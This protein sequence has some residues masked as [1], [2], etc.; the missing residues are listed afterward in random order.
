M[1]LDSIAYFQALATSYNVTKATLDKMSVRGWNTL[2]AFAFSCSAPQGVGSEDK[3]AIEVFRSLDV[4]ETA[5]APGLRRLYFDAW[6]A[7]S[8]VTKQKFERREDDPPRKLPRIELQDRRAALQKILGKG[9]KLEH[10]N[11]PSDALV[12]LANAMLENDVVRHIHVSKCTSRAQELREI[13]VEPSLALDRNGFLKLGEQDTEVHADCSS[14]L[15]VQNAL[16]RRG[17]AL[18]LANVLDFE[19]HSLLVADFMTAAQRPIPGHGVI[20]LDRLLLW[21]QEIWYRLSQVAT[22]GVKTSIDGKRPLDALLL[23]VLVEP[24]LAILLLPV[25]SQNA[26]Q[27]KHRDKER[28]NSGSGWRDNKISRLEQ[29]IANLKRGRQTRG[30]GHGKGAG[31][32]KDKG[33][34]GPCIRKGELAGCPYTW[35]GETPLLHGA[36]EGVQE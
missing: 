12:D 5:E 19:V 23:Q 29:E 13:K 11:D 34:A 3:F 26:E 16:V 32:G 22:S 33:K 9:L 24:R 6:V 10:E 30:G 1:S 8:A 18:H 17:L 36:G 20:S 21:D 25:Q 31:K 35:A 27:G 15:K 4:L 7:A 14:L 28:A 2:G